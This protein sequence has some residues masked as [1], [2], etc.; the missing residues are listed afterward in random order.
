MDGHGTSPLG[1]CEEIPDPSEVS[2]LGKLS[3][4]LMSYNLII[5]NNTN[6]DLE[7]KFLYEIFDSARKKKYN[8]GQWHWL[9]SLNP[10]GRS[11]G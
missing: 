5:R 6:T 2:L 8:H 3:V 9:S 10:C 11:S 1:R 7:I 4:Y